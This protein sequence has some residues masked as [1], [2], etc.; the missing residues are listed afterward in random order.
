ML[1]LI[2]TAL[3]VPTWQLF[4]TTEDLHSTEI[5][6]PFVALVRDGNQVLAFNSKT[7]L[8]DYVA[9]L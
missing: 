3:N 1:E 7:E 2:A 6:Q 4:A 8:K 9:S 5:Q